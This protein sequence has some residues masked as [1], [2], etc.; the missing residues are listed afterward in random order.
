MLT[1]RELELALSETNPRLR[2]T[3]APDDV[4]AMELASSDGSAFGLN[5]S[6][7]EREWSIRRALTEE[8]VFAALA[9]PP[10]RV[11]WRNESGSNWL[12][13]VRN[14]RNCGSCVAFATCAVLE[15][16]LAIDEG[17]PSLGID[18][19]EADLFF[20]GC[21]RCCDSG[22]TF[23]PAL[24][25]CQEHGV[26]LERDFAYLA[27]NQ[28]CKPVSPA[29]GVLSWNTVANVDARKR[30]VAQGPVI[31][32]LKVYEDFTYYQAGTYRHVAGAFLGLHAVAV[33]GYDDSSSAWI[34][35]NSWSSRW[36]EAGFVNIAYGQCG[37]DSDFPF[38]DPEVA[39]WSR[40]N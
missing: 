6:T 14:Q 34:V 7:A 39:R 5:I 38:Y 16:R 11:D 37:L 28:N 26:G 32:G 29:V 9:P 33:V 30:A 4:L 13:P 40:M 2:W 31:A 24:V 12:T 21:G 1:L 18:L 20:C 8:Q 15:S 25:R 27:R 23:D 36:G 35:K 17:D 19:A 22:W 10:S 3:P